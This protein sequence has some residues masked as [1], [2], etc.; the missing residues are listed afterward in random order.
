MDGSASR[1]QYKTF[2]PGDRVTVRRVIKSG[3][4][5]RV[6]TPGMAGVVESM[7]QE[8]RVQFSGYPSVVWILYDGD[9][10]AFNGEMP[11]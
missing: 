11:S 5:A 8:V 4:S 9:L 3:K 7:D 6:I 10:V 1:A 2:R